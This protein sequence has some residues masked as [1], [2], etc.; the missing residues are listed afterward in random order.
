VQHDVQSKQ[1]YKD[2]VREDQ[3]LCIQHALNR[4]RYNVDFIKFGFIKYVKDHIR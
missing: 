1:K 4:D 2:K 3:T